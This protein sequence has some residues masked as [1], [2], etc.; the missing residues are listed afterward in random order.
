MDMLGVGIDLMAMVVTFVVLIGVLLGQKNVMNEYFPILLLVNALTILADL[1][2]Y[3]FA[4]DVTHLTMLRLSCI[5]QFSF[6]FC[7][8]AGF[9]LY[10]DKMIR[11]VSGKKPLLRIIPYILTSILIVLWITSLATGWFFQVSDEGN[12]TFGPYFIYIIFAGVLIAVFDL[13]R[14]LVNHANGTIESDIAI[15]MY[16]F[17]ALPLLSLPFACMLPCMSLFFGAV[18]VS[19]L[20]MYIMIHVRMEHASIA[21]E[22]E[23]RKIQIA[24]IMSQIQPHFVFNS[25]TTIQYLCR[26]DLPLA[27]EA[28]G[29][30]TKYLRRNLD[31]VASEDLVPFSEELE[32]TKTY[33]WLEQLR[34]GKNLR[35]EYSIDNASFLVPP[36]SLQPIVENA[37]KHGVTKKVGGGTVSI[38]VRE[39]DRFYRIIVEDDGIGFDQKQMEQRNENDTGINDIRKRLKSLNGSRLKIKSQEGI[40]TTVTYEI[41]KGD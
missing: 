4:G 25:L 1:G 34:F 30:F 36:L 18:S 14:I 10:V 32:H 37:V 2:T 39:L 38:S 12:Y 22:M 20:V 6:A 11:R 40:G 31:S 23:E 8:I 28:L 33:L 24:L 13:F 9:N 3:A 26:N 19:Y 15:G 27:V 35:V 41:V 29:K 17:F 5:L 7:G 21:K 16:L